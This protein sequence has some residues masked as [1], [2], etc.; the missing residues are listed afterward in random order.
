M[1]GEGK[2]ELTHSGR[3]GKAFLERVMAK[4]RA[5]LERKLIRAMGREV[6]GSGRMQPCKGPVT[7]T[8]LSA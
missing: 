4:L 1:L 6:R 8:L 2:V 3:S 7:E 5:G